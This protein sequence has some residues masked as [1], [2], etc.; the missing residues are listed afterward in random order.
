MPKLS[1]IFE[2]FKDLDKISVKDI[3]RWLKP[4]PDDITLHNF[5]ANRV[6]YP[7]T[8]P[9]NIQELKF[10]L[11]IL[12]E[13]LVHDNRFLNKNNKK[14]TV[15]KH[16][17]ARFPDISGLVSAFVNGY[18]YQAKDPSGIWT[19]AERGDI[20]EE[21]LATVLVP[22]F[23]SGNS[24]INLTLN[25]QKIT[26]KAGELIVTPCNEEKCKLMFQLTGGTFLGRVEGMIEVSGKLG[27]VLV[28]GR[29]YG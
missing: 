19:V 14:I 29:R 28:D 13:L 20:R 5:Y 9:V 15:P 2:E 8:I 27:E 12:T 17:I 3:A 26:V 1:G 22:K 4:I 21:R 6:Y 23:E 10:D 18:I 11:A 25:S 7:Q 24:Q 16:F